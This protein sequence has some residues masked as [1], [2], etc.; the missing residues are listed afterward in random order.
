M[1][2]DFL[3]EKWRKISVQD[4]AEFASNSCSLSTLRRV[5]IALLEW[6]LS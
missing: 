3:P 2:A 1:V 4:V 5:G 6:E